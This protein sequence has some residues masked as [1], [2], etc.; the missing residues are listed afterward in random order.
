[1]SLSRRHD[2]ASTACASACESPVSRPH[3]FPAPAVFVVEG[4]DSSLPTDARLFLRRRL[5]LRAVLLGLC[6]RGGGP[7][8]RAEGQR[9]R[10]APPVPLRS[11]DRR[12]LRPGA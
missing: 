6:R 8:R 4:G 7:A 3:A 1:R 2:L 5:P 9:P 10:R 12:W 11:L